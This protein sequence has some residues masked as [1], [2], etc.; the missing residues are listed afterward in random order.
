MTAVDSS[1]SAVERIQR[2]AA[3]N[4]LQNMKAVKANVF[5]LLKDY[6]SGRRT[7]DAIMLDP[8]TFAK[9]RRHLEQ[10][11]RAYREID[12]KALELLECDGV[13]VTCLCSH[14]FSEA[15]LLSVVADAANHAHERVRVIEWRT[16]ARDHAILLTVPE[17]HYLKCLILQVI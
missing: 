14:H 9:S 17:T 15:D 16:Q 2:N 5:E 1:E 3:R 10:A 7:F 13:L 4:E 11:A 8:P 6:V 12:Y